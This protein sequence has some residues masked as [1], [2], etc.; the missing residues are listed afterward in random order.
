MKYKLGNERFPS[1]KAVTE[2]GS[3]ILKSG[4]VSERDHSFL[5]ALF[6]NHAEWSEKEGNGVASIRVGNDSTINPGG[7]MLNKCFW[8]MRRDGSEVS[9]SFRHCIRELGGRGGGAM[10]ATY[11]TAARSAISAQ[12]LEFKSSVFGD[13]ETVFCPDT[14]QQ[15]DWDSAVVDH[16]YPDTFDS[17]LCE[18][19]KRAGVRNL[20]EVE[21]SDYIFG[22]VVFEQRWQ[23]YHD[24]NAKLEVV[25]RK[26]NG[27]RGRA[28]V[29]WSFLNVG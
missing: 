29:N 16:V 13:N 6:Q 18:F 3:G 5:M 26:A 15:L 9:I 23:E 12:V 28:S 17:L 7:W 21:I 20:H 8:L 14:G 4:V 22:N 11:K 24:R 1:K 2:R 25:S 10:L 27:R 19:T